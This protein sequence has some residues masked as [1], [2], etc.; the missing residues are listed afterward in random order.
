MREMRT[1]VSAVAVI[2]LL[3][4]GAIGVPGAEG[5]AG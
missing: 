1:T 4:M 3:V 2:G 5:Y